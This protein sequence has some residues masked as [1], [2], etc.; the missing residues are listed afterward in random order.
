MRERF[1]AEPHPARREAWSRSLA[2]AHGCDASSDPSR[3]T[4]PEECLR[5]GPAVHAFTASGAVLAVMALLAIQAGDLGLGDG[6]HVL[7]ALVHRL[8]WTAPSRERSASR[9]HLRQINGRRM[10]DVVDYLNFVIV[11]AVFMVQAGS[12]LARR[13]WHWPVL[14]SAFGFSR[15]GRQDRRRLLSRLAIVLERAGASTCGCSIISP[16]GGTIWVGRLCDR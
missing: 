15:D 11:P 1:H 4:G 16:L 2:S 9:V 3:S 6:L 14:A 8:P 12:V 7:I 5:G 13:G 10:D